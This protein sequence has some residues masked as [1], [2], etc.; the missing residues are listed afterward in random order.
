MM[1]YLRGYTLAHLEMKALAY[2]NGSIY[3]IV[4]YQKFDWW[5]SMI[6][7]PYALAQ[8]LQLEIGTYLKEGIH[9][10]NEGEWLKWDLKRLTIISIMRLKDSRKTWLCHF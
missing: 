8:F 10:H 6:S 3:L 7:A 2:E 1:A 9:L 5:I 4:P